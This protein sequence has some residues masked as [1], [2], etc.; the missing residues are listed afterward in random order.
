MP[1]LL[2]TLRMITITHIWRGCDVSRA[3]P[4]AR[5]QA[6]R[7]SLHCPSPALTNVSPL[8]QPSIEYAILMDNLGTHCPPTKHHFATHG[9]GN[10]EFFS[11]SI[12][13]RDDTDSGIH[14]KRRE[15][16]RATYLDSPKGLP[17]A[18]SEDPPPYKFSSSF[19]SS[20]LDHDL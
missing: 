8:L 18:D 3:R 14:Q 16:E 12:T 2:C 13:L 4:R 10:F 9:G 5:K 19:N 17:R 15:V 7:Y 11:I 6:I 1:T 20:L